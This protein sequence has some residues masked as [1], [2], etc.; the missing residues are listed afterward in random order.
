MTEVGAGM[1]AGLD[2]RL[3]GN[4]VG[5]CGKG[6]GMDGMGAGEEGMTTGLDSRLRGNDV[7][8]WVLGVLS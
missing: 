7:G 6:R 8:G 3:R 4:D 5:G 2:S 1:T